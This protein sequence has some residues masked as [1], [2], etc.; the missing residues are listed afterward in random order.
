[1][2]RPR[3]LLVPAFT[4]LEWSIRP[5][6][7]DWADVASF[8]PPGI[9]EEPPPPHGLG[10]LKREDVARRGLEEAD[11][12]G[13]D[14]FVLLA[15]GFGIGAAAKLA[16][17][18]PGSIEGFAFGHAVVDYK[19]D[20][21]APTVNPGTFAA[22]SQL[23]DSDA[24]SFIR[25]A[26]SQFTQ[27]GYDEALADRMVERF[28]PA[29][30]GPDLRRVWEG[31]SRMEPPIGDLLAGFDPPTLLAEHKGCLGF[32]PEGFA[33]AVAYFPEAR[34]ISLETTP[35]SSPEFAEAVRET[36]GPA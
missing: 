26:I 11:R 1:L 21:P 25:Y 18:R 29:A 5:R 13:W 14:R 19:L 32:T 24:P 35:C 27:G 22:M 23:L 30:H 9:G 20:G 28:G 16:A 2:Q 7:E 10:E 31:L 3:L 8:D 33:A 15:D 36:F 6:L 34:A 17:M 4:E 12:N